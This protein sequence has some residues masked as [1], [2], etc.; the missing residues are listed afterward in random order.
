[1]DY[2]LLDLLFSV[3]FGLMALC[4][5]LVSATAFYKAQPVIEFMCEVLDIRNIDEQPKTLT[6]SQRVRF[7]KEIKGKRPTGRKVLPERHNKP[8]TRKHIGLRLSC[9]TLQMHLKILP[10]HASLSTVTGG[11]SLCKDLISL[12]AV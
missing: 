1:M 10:R 7:T 6:D 8:L 3:F 4:L 5:P 12:L 9:L 2:L 11:V